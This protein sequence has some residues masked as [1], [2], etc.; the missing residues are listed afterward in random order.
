[1]SKDQSRA[2]AIFERTSMSQTDLLCE[3][4]GYVISGLPESGNCPECGTPIPESLPESR[5]GS[6]WQARIRTGTPAALG[7]WL[8]TSWNILRHPA[9]TFRSL[10]ADMPG[11]RS[12]LSINLLASGV[13][14]AM[15]WTGVWLYDPARGSRGVSGVLLQLASLVAITIVAALILLFLTWVECLGIRFFAARRSWRL[16]RAMAWQVCA[17]ASVGWLAAG[18]CV[19][20]ALLLT[21]T[22]AGSTQMIAGIVSVRDLIGGGLIFTAVLIGMLTFEMLVYLGVRQCRFAN[23][24]RLA[25]GPGGDTIAP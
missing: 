25:G 5:V 1:M 8:S 22:L 15:P 2:D 7:A 10:R 14:L 16:T 12:H 20:G 17:H 19:W 11:V 13:L 4:C 6:P 23:P 21:S 9:P 3:S 24:P 18:P